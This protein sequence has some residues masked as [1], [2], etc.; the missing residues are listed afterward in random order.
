MGIS[1]SCK[2]CQQVKAEF[3]LKSQEEKRSRIDKYLAASKRALL[4]DASSM[5]FD[6]ACVVMEV[7][8][9]NIQDANKTILYV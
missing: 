4:K 2:S 5:V 7:E 1:N 9:R 6:E 8:L 3:E